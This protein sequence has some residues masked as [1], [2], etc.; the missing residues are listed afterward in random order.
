[1]ALKN[2]MK[3]DT[4]FNTYIAMDIIGEGGAGHIYKA[5]DGSRNLVAI[6]LLNSSRLS[7]ENLKRF[8][9]EIHFCLR[10]KHP[11]IVTVI[12]HGVYI[13][14]KL[15]IPFYVMPLYSCSLRNLIKSGIPPDNV[16]PYFSQIL[17]GVEAAHLQKVIHRDLKPENIL[18]N[19]DKNVFSI[20]DFGIAQF[21]QEELFT[22]VETS[23]GTRL[24]NFQYAAPEQRGRGQIIDNYTD[25][26]A[27]GLIL[28]EMFT[29]QVP[30]G[31]AYKT[32]GSVSAIYKYLDELV[33]YM[34]R[35][36][37]KERPPSI[38]V[39]KRELIRSKNE[40]ITL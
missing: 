5:D 21:Q 30:Q 24:A 9:N 33:S 15:N 27:L 22:A 18:F 36:S 13:E 34:L 19:K 28:N 12:D 17:D 8:K 40:F 10:N 2:A 35:Q 25:I 4:T 26:Y 7:S 3:F 37:P 11:N 20:A 32:I 14:N 39:V 1:M 38:E 31:T 16:L 29:K 23:D 6:K